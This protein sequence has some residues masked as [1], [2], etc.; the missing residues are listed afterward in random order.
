MTDA[1]YEENFWAAHPGL[2][3]EIRADLTDRRKRRPRPQRDR[4]QGLDNTAD[5]G[6]S[7]TQHR[8]AR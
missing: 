4:G 8:S 6:H 1:E 3:E 2:Q 7:S 5:S